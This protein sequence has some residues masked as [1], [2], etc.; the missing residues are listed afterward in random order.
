MRSEHERPFVCS[1]SP[2]SCSV[3]LVGFN[4][5]TRLESSFW[6]FWSDDEGFD[7]VGFMS[8][9]ER[10]RK[11]AGVRKR[12]NEMVSKFHPGSVL[13]TNICSEPTKRAADLKPKDRRTDVFMFLLETIR[14]SIVF[15]HSNEPIRYFRTLLNGQQIEFS[16]HAIVETSVLGGPLKICASEGPLWRKKVAEVS[17][18]AEAL[19]KHASTA[20]S[21]P[22]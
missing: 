10:L 16:H 21:M 19:S 1:G 2:L 9:Y 7:R 8:E 4:P 11:V 3:F 18:L 12:L 6:S 13:E 5:A 17:A 22:T 15:L 20:S 14:P